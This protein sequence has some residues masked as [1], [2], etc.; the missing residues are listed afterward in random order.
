MLDLHERKEGIRGCVKRRSPLPWLTGNQILSSVMFPYDHTNMLPAISPS[1]KYILRLYFNGCYRKVVLDDLLPTSTDS[2][3]F[4]V[5]DRCNP[6]YLW[7]ALV[8]KAYLKVRGG[9]DFPGSN[10]GTDIAVLTGWLPE[11]IFLHN[12]DVMPEELWARVFRAFTYGDVLITIGTGKF[13]KREQRHLGLAAEHDYTILNMKETNGIREMLIKNPW[14][15]GDVWK[16]GSRRTTISDNANE[17]QALT[18]MEQLSIE[19]DDGTLAPGTFWMDLSS[20]FQHFENLYL[21]WNPGLFSYRQDYHFSWDLSEQQS[22]TGSFGINPQFAVQC[23]RSGSLWLLLNRHF[24]TGDY[25]GRNKGPYGFISLY[26]FNRRGQR[27]LLSDGAMMRGPYVDSPNVLLKVDA[28]ANTEYTVVAAAQDLPSTKMNFTLSAFA[29]CPIGLSMARIHYLNTV[30]KSAAWTRS[31]AGGNSDSPA[32]LANPQFALELSSKAEIAVLL[33]SMQ[34]TTEAT[35]A[36][37][38]KI[39]F[40]K[41]LRV[42]VLRTMDIVAHSGDYRRGSAALETILDPGTYTI[43]CSTF[44]AAQVGKF[45]LSV[46][47]SSETPPNLRPLSAEGSGRLTSVSLP[48]IFAASM[49]RL[50]APVT[51]T[52]LTRASLIVRPL[53]N[54]VAGSNSPRTCS[55][56]KLTLEQGQGPYKTCLATSSS[57]DEHEYNDPASGVRI[58]D[59]DIRPEIH[60]PWTGGLWIVLHRMTGSST[61]MQMDE[62]FEVLVMAEDRVELGAWGVGEG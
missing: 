26:L 20:V 44:D 15:D 57:S 34:P 56:M 38:I 27:V 52:R 4:H 13:S 47:S 49:S 46:H 43:V 19:A 45:K 22:M 1:S 16:G 11:Q 61:M 51:A 9:Y 14:S 30:S 41:G 23:S 7:P 31:T 53:S 33:E 28:R 60:G 42:T 32:Y 35:V 8:E 48:A 10:S 36:V 55:P 18:A 58:D 50:L 12:E 24:R 3:I 37:H 40:T 59:F 2:R 6:G 39:F 54:Q 62:T 5:V 25:Q 29:R 17:Q 21:N